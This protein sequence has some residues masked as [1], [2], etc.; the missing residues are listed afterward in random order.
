MKK[1]EQY[2]EK[3]LRLIISFQSTLYYVK[4]RS[5]QRGKQITLVLHRYIFRYTRILIDKKGEVV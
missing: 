1:L 2:D 3:T 4:L 5:E